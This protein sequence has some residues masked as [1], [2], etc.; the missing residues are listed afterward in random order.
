MFSFLYYLQIFGYRNGGSC[1]NTFSNTDSEVHTLDR[2]KSSVYRDARNALAAYSTKF[3]QFVIFIDGL[4]A[5]FK[6][7]VE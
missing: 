1:Q 2:P 4:G 7:V 5:A 3:R 6:N